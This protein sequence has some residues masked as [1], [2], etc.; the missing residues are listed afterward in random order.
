MW[1]D[2]T[3]LI[4]N[5]WLRNQPG[6]NIRS[7]TIKLDTT[8]LSI[9]DNGE[10]L[11]WNTVT[12]LDN[13]C[14]IAVISPITGK[15]I[16]KSI[17]CTKKLPLNIL[18]CIKGRPF[19]SK[20]TLSVTYTRKA[21]E[22]YTSTAKGV[23]TRKYEA[24]CDEKF[25]PI[26]VSEWGEAMCC[27]RSRTIKP[28]TRG[29]KDMNNARLV[30]KICNLPGSR[31][32]LLNSCNGQIRF[33]IISTPSTTA[34]GG[35][36]SLIHC[37]RA[38]V[39][40][41]QVCVH[42]LSNDWPFDI[43]TSINS[44]R[45]II[46]GGSEVDI[47]EEDTQQLNSLF[48]ILTK[49]TVSGTVVSTFAFQLVT[50]NEEKIVQKCSDFQLSCLNNLCIS[51][52]HIHEH[53][54]NCILSKSILQPQQ[55]S[56]Y[57]FTCQSG[58]CL[59]WLN[60]CDGK[61]HCDDSSD[62]QRC[63]PIQQTTEE[64]TTSDTQFYKCIGGWTIS[65]SLVNDLVPDCPDGEDENM[66]SD[67][68]YEEPHSLT[69]RCGK[70]TPFS[71]IP[72]HVK[73][74]ALHSLCKLAFDDVGHIRYC[75]NGAHL[76]H[77]SNV[78][79]SAMYKCT[80]SY[81][82]PL[83]MYCDS[84]ADC[85]NGDDEIDCYYKLSDMSG[86]LMCKGGRLLHPLH[87]CDGDSDCPQGDDELLCDLAPC[88]QQCM[89]FGLS[90]Y[91]NL[92]LSAHEKIDIN[93][94]K[95]FIS[96]RQDTF[97]RLYNTTRLMKLLITNSKLGGVYVLDL[98]Y[99]QLPSVLDLDL[100]FCDISVVTKEM[101]HSMA[102][103]LSFN[104]SFNR[105]SSIPGSVFQDNRHLEIFDL[106]NQNINDL[107][108][109]AFIGLENL[110]SLNLSNNQILQID[111]ASFSAMDNLQ[112]VSLINNSLTNIE[113]YLNRTF[114]MEFQT[115]KPQ[116]CCK[117][118]QKHCLTDKSTLCLHF[119]STTA[120]GGVFISFGLSIL[121]LN[122]V[123]ITI[124]IIRH[125]RSHAQNIL[126]MS[127]SMAGI[128]YGVYLLVLGF[129]HVSFH[130][131]FTFGGTQHGWCMSCS[132]LQMYSIMLLV[133]L[134][135]LTTFSY[136]RGLLSI[137][138]VVIA[139]KLLLAFVL[140]LAPP[141]VFYFN[142]NN[143]FGDGYIDLGPDCSMASWKQTNSPKHKILISLVVLTLMIQIMCQCFAAFQAYRSVSKFVTILDS[144]TSQSV[145]SARHG[146]VVK[147]LCQN[148]LVIL[149]GNLMALAGFFYTLLA[150]KPIGNSVNAFVTVTSS[151]HHILAPI[152]YMLRVMK[153]LSGKQ[154]LQ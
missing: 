39:M 28:W 150:T 71:C 96:Q 106:S 75:R 121:L 125:K 30:E 93:L 151:L 67:L 8:G 50:L 135:T 37:P 142:A 32:V 128:V 4:Y 153:A 117:L 57:Y 149:L 85:P 76:T 6:Q 65:Y 41:G 31:R 146:E 92:D 112:W 18:V 13:S 99:L 68:A 100:T 148:E 105:L 7:G 19:T 120:H 108:P 27:G 145:L 35:N 86:F 54:P 59:P 118:D 116:L 46:V 89:C 22:K 64:P 138:K 47:S 82:I 25:S 9:H 123:V 72:G 63:P 132:V 83:Y 80:L 69:D 147:Y 29:L 124:R 84:K 53:I 77:C 154:L 38:Q 119:A 60:V 110:R 24:L 122:A 109:F 14:A 111:L 95:S 36:A 20:Q 79:C 66:M 34:Q 87:V 26:V 49:H 78:Q 129:S 42:L 113:S 5:S 23:R 143:A 12:N 104:L 91:C 140:N 11:A 56:P 33:N 141:V 137:T 61:A 1:T 58:K 115:N 21:F 133:S 40:V 131:V 126:M 73:C 136:S 114:H 16:W 48:N 102:N 139:N 107:S 94:Y 81:C 127:V 43:D 3:P 17:S 103:A 55:C 134:S 144:G 2:N 130:G 152:V 97:P 70:Q 98:S 52:D 10:S 101:F 15:L 44:T 88:P 45:L 90:M 51:I 62:E 74:F